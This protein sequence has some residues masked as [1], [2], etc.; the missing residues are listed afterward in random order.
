MIL[1]LSWLVGDHDNANVQENA[2]TW[3]PA[4]VIQAS[5]LS[6]IECG[7]WTDRPKP[8]SD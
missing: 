5:K 8:A 4:T 1:S 6:L 2:E 3:S 7:V